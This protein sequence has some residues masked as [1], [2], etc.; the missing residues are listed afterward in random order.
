MDNE[1]SEITII[2][3]GLCG[4][5]KT[6]TAAAIAKLLIDKGARVVIQDQDGESA[7]LRAMVDDRID[8]YANNLN[9]TIKTVSAA[10]RSTLSELEK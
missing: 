2:V 10:Y 1:R 7:A 5:G 4:S 9:V 8:T 6:G 3:S